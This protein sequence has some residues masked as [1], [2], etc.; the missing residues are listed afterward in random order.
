MKSVLNT[1]T[2]SAPEKARVQAACQVLGANYARQP[3]TRKKTLQQGAQPRSHQLVLCPI[4][5][6]MKQTGYG[7]TPTAPRVR[8]RSK[9]V[10][11]GLSSPKEVP[12]EK[13]VVKHRPSGGKCHP[14]GAGRFS[15]LAMCR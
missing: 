13:D 14:I 7:L 8:D 4:D 5:N 12:S 11:R 3:S 1:T 6:R 15:S 9:E 10:L 2:S